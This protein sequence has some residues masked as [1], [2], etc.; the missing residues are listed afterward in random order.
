MMQ[1]VEIYALKLTE[2]E[3]DHLLALLRMGCREIEVYESKVILE[4]LRDTLEATLWT[5]Y[6]E[7]L[8]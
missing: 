3:R 5:K 1:Q 7:L 2:P 4:K 8:P 6:K